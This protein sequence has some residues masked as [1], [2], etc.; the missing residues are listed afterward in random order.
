MMRFV[1]L[2]CGIVLVA[3]LLVRHEKAA[4]PDVPDAIIYVREPPAELGE[5]PLPTAYEPDLGRAIRFSATKWT[6]EIAVTNSRDRITQVPITGLAAKWHVSGGMVGVKGWTSDKYKYLPATVTH[7]VGNIS[8]LNSLGYYQQNRGVRRSYPDGTEF[9]DVL[10]NADGVVF[11]HRTRKKMNG[12]WDSQVVYR[13][14]AARPAGYFGLKQSCASCHNEAGT[15]GYAVGLVP[16]GDTV[17]SDPLDWSV[18]G[19]R[20]WD[21]RT[22]R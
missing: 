14:V 8:V 11:E 22:G 12:V 3:A 9:H 2:V 1:L 20:L 19:N 18:A 4:V 10:R 21:W 17:L 5:P 6:Q 13:D 16:G 7:W 15:G